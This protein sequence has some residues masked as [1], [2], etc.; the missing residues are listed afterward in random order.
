MI[1]TF[2]FQKSEKL[3]HF[4]NTAKVSLKNELTVRN[5]KM[6][7]VKMAIYQTTQGEAGGGHAAKVTNSG[8]DLSALNPTQTLQWEFELGAGEEK[9]FEFNYTT[10]TTR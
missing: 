8:R 4:Y 7:P 3:R 2:P 10:I 5:L 1:L 9:K 6:A